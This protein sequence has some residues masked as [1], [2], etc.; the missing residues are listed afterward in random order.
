MSTM[1]KRLLIV[2]AA[3]F[4][5]IL[6]G[7][8]SSGGGTVTYPVPVL[9]SINSTATASGSAGTTFIVYGSG[10][11]T[12]SG[13]SPVSGYSVDFRDRST[14]NIIGSA[15]WLAGGWHDAYIKAVVPN[16]LTVGTTYN[17]T[18]TTPGGVTKSASFL[19]TQGVAF[20]PSTLSWAATAA[21]PTGIQGFP[22][23]VAPLSG[24]TYIYTLGGNTGLS[25]TTGA[26]KSNIADVNYN[27]LNTTNSVSGNAG[28]LVNTA[29]TATTALPLERGF[30]AGTIATSFNSL[31]PA[32]ANGYVYVLGG[33][34][35]T[36]AAQ[37]TVYYAQVN[38][39]GTL[40]SWNTTTAMPQALYGHGVAI[41]HGQLYVAGGNDSS[42][43]PTKTVYS[44]V[45][46]TDGTLGSWSTL[47]ALPTAI[48]YHQLVTAGGVLYV[49]GGTST[50]SVDPTSSTQSA[51]SSKSVYYNLINLVDG[52]LAT[53]WT[54]T[55][56][57]TMN[58]EK[59]T[60]VA[61]GANI[62]V[63]G[64]LFGATGP[65][66]FQSS[67][68]SYATVNADGSLGS[69]LGA[70]GAKTINSVASNT[71]FNHSV[72]FFADAAGNPHVLILGGQD[73]T[74]TV[75]N[76]EVWYQQ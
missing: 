46:N 22:T 58:R 5:T 69:F 52:T 4:Y 15:S 6:T 28:S 36:G 44:A 55:S 33:L 3:G 25:G 1:V 7:C 23:V 60:A 47:S 63:S 16:T 8:S 64:G 37:A 61:V 30:S 11:G 12:L 53:N 13:A 34:D 18:V 73:I 62:L 21:L 41:F 27:Q 67:E 54:T 57:M 75:M 71:F 56:S 2:L 76:T 66:S 17:V 70:T 39:D 14:N 43:N 20:S 48:A 45:I 51:N 40:G 38:P 35:A 10:F 72:T 31:V 24:G 32:S 9:T 42:G 68:E 50:A 65:T 29:W 59:H 49:L 19:V 26:M 74:G